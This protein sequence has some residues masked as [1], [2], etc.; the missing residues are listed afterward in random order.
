MSM[1][2][3]QVNSEGGKSMGVFHV[4]IGIGN[5]NGGNM[6]HVEAMVDTGSIHSV[7]PASLLES[8]DIAPL[9]QQP[10][11]L[12]DGSERVFGLGIAQLLVLG[13]EFPCPVIFGQ[14]EECLLGATTLETLQLMVDPVNE[15]LVPTTPR[16]RPI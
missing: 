10:F 14:S 9:Q 13:R 8:I 12:A 16:A 4:T 7:V 15:T 2:E 6:K 1:I 11:I 3:K 5:P